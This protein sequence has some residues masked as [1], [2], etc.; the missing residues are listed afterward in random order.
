MKTNRPSD[1]S[2]SIIILEGRPHTHKSTGSNE[3]PR[4]YQSVEVEHFIVN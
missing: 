3:R 2:D 1:L 4:V